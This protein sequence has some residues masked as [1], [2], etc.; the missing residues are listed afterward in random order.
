MTRMK[1]LAWGVAV[2]LAGAAPA[3]ADSHADAP[4]S[5]RMRARSDHRWFVPRFTRRVAQAA[6]DPAPADPPADPAAAPA[7]PA[8]APAPEPAAPAP[9]PTV[10]QTPQLSD[11]ELA[12][13]AEQEAKTE[14]I[15]VTGSTI[16]RKTLTTPAPVTILSREDLNAAGRST[17]GDIIQALP[18]QSNAINAQT[19]NGGDGSTRVNIRGL[20]TARTL[21]LV[22][23]RRVVA[24][25]VGADDSVDLNAIPL[26]VIERV[27]VLKDGASAV[28]GSDAVGGVV[29]LITRT[30]FNGT[31]A[32]LFTGGSP[33][34]DGFTYDASFVTGHTSEDKKGNI[35]FSAGVQ[36]QDS[37]FAGDR[38]FSQVQKTFD[39]K[40]G[41]AN[42]SGSTAV[43][44]GRIDT[45]QLDVDGDGK[46]DPVAIPGCTSKFCKS[47]RMGGFTNFDTQNDLYNFQPVNYLFT[48]SERY[49]V[50][51]S[52]SYKLTPSISGFFE[53]SY[54]NRTSDQELAPE[55][56]AAAAMVSKASYY[57]PLGADVL[58]LRRRLEE[59]GPRHAHQSV[60]TFR[61]VAGFNGR[62]AEDAPAFKDWKWELSY[63]Y[64]RTDATQINTGNLILSRLANALGPSFKNA[65]GQIQCGAPDA[66]IAGCVP[67]NILG[68]ARDAAGRPS[69]TQDMINYVT[70][71]G[72]NSGYNEQ[73]TVLA[74]AHGRIAKLPNNGDIALAVGADYRKTSGGFT[75]D[76]LTS[77]G[78]TTGNA[79]APTNGS[80]NV[81]EGYGELSIVPLSGKGLAQWV[82]LD[83]AARA[84]RYNNFGSGVTWK[85]GGLFRTV[86]GIAVRG[87]YSTAFR[88]PSI[89]ELFLGAADDFQSV[90]DPCDANP[91]STGPRVLDD[92]TAQ[93]CIDQGVPVGREFGTTQQR[94]I[95]GGNAKLKAE[96]AKVLTAGL[97]VEPPQVKG[98]ALTV[99]YWR[100]AID[101]AIQVL[102]AS[103]IFANCYTRDVPGY[104]ERIHRDPISH[105][106]DSVDNPVSNVGGATTSGLDVAVVSDRSY[107]ELGRLRLQAE[108]QYLFL[109]DIDN[110]VQ[111]LHGRGYFD[112]GVFPKI[113]ANLSAMYQHPV[114][115]GGGFNLRYVGAYKECKG[116]DCNTAENLEMS[117]REVSQWFKLDVFASY[118]VKT[119]AGTT[120]LAV[121]VNNLLDSQPPVI[122]TGPAANAANSDP[123]TYD[124]MGRFVYA[125]LSQMF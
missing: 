120:T 61:I 37:V 59:F 10:D 112:L 103:A 32:N 121:G 109:A 93:K 33:H 73:Q 118:A 4:S 110:S 125:R 25:G 74:E 41:A 34:G 17:V 65:D 119:R 124:Y 98:L 71:T 80:Y 6:P 111:V 28:Y 77:T 19:N 108:G 30:D 106:I 26:A 99:D 21:V 31:E 83:L 96:T 95:D 14:V 70:F 105:A 62:V 84:F 50:Y 38:S 13:L 85:A 42:P 16:E 87:T 22:N 7:E 51:G 48:P 90:E 27:E 5:L 68:P 100:V 115:A 116:N 35:V 102:G 1:T 39:F 117:S 63:N 23:G 3:A 86:N 15:T 18:A 60:D 122:Y 88:A 72:V 36:R 107:G 64:G 29:N 66:V 24:G 78:D 49:N 79:I 101:D 81:G 92:K 46:P 76:P 104:C 53:S 113:K 123:G 75:P 8:A 58:D 114:G 94:A 9:A 97:V 55:P 56:F 82:E 43:P 45:T 20:G 89:A 57:N 54:L 91:P 2:L 11:E 67:M 44:D 12:K 47:D 69:I 52:G 40:T